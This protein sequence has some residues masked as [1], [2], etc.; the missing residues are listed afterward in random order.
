[1]E[2]EIR[3]VEDYELIALRVPPGDR[4]R[5]TEDDSNVE[6][7]EGIVEAMSEYMRRNNFKGDYRLSPLD[8][9]GRIY[10]IKESREVISQPVKVI[11]K[12]DLYGEE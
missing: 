3:V 5:L 4:W 11:K 12:Y 6:P 10:A 7:I 9:G 2:E 8:K 1:M